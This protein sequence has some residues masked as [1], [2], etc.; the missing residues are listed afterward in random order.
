[1]GTPEQNLADRLYKMGKELESIMEQIWV[2]GRHDVGFQLTKG[3]V[4]TAIHLAYQE[5]GKT[6]AQESR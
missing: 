4:F 5:A 3:E 2:E 1:M 6:P